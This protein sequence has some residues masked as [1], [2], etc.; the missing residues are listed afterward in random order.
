VHAIV[1]A[2]VSTSDSIAFSDEHGAA[3]AA[4]AFSDDKNC[5]DTDG[6]A[7]LRL[8]PH[9]L[10]L[11]NVALSLRLNS[12]AN[13][14]FMEIPETSICFFYISSLCRFCLPKFASSG[15]MLDAEGS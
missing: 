13:S 2:G 4:T 7:Q 14:A 6:I 12:E 9:L 11:S 15:H 5:E 1:A 8:L 3:S 10:V